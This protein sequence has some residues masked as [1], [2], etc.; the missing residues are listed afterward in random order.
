M[1][2]VW[3]GIAALI[4]L[5]ACSGDGGRSEASSTAQGANAIVVEVIDGDTITVE[6][7]GDVE[8]VRLI[9][10]DTPE[11]K[12]PRK[13][14]E[15]YG[16]EASDFTASLL[17]IGTAILLERDL[18]GRDDYGRLLGYVHLPESDVFVNREIIRRGYAQPMTIEPN[19][20][21]AGD[22][23]DDARAAERENLGIW[24]ECAG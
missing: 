11:T 8:R 17:P 9:G 3:I 1:K 15:C 6:I 16:P 23:A 19:S 14:I 20:T 18:V 13:P 2:S 4:A 22:F 5:T 7:D 24:A 21:Y 12:H 10:I